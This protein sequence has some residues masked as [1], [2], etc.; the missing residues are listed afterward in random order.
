[1][2][3]LRI[4]GPLLAAALALG[5]VP[6]VAAEETLPAACAGKA[7]VL[8]EGEQLVT[9]KLYFH[10]SSAVGDVD[11]YPSLTNGAPGPQTLSPTAPTGTQSKVDTNLSSSVYFVPLP[12]NPMM[13]AWHGTFE[14]TTRIACFGFDYWAV[15]DGGAMEVQL[16]A[17]QALILGTGAPTT[18]SATASGPGAARYTA[19]VQPSQPITV[20]FDYF[21]QIEAVTPAA[22]LYDSVDHPSSIT[23]VTIEPIPTPAP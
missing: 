22:I 4:V 2:K 9:K 12:G 20:E 18:A 13:S 11:S 5:T 23:L 3:T 19:N 14:N 8:A 17:D 10:G 15:S 7:P 6:G 1:M 21:A 16:W